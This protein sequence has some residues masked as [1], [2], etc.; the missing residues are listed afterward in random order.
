MDHIGQ[1]P[2]SGNRMVSR[3]TGPA[4]HLIDRYR[5]DQYP[6]VN[7]RGIEGGKVRA[8]GWRALPSTL[9]L[10]TMPLQSDFQPC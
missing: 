5:R 3:T 6:I 7:V 2:P 1:R 8:T 10:K 4:R 9:R